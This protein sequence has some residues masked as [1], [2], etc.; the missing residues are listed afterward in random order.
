MTSSQPCISPF[1]PIYIGVNKIP[2][3]LG[4]TR[5]YELFEKLR[6]AVEYH[7]EYREEI[8]RYWS[9]FEIQAIEESYLLEKEA[10]ALVDKG[11]AAEAREMLTV[12]VQRKCDESMTACEKMLEFLSGLPVLS[13][14]TKA[15]PE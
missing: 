5:A 9:V 10:T 2:E 14:G 11:Q 12:F 8:T 6:F 7:T 4:T 3:A 13:K 15:S 1:L